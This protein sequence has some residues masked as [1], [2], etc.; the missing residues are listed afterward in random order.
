MLPCSMLEKKIDAVAIAALHPLAVGPY[1]ILFPDALF[2]PLDR[3]AMVS[4][5]GLHPLLILLGPFGQ[6]VFGEGVEAMHV[7]KEMDDVLRPC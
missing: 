7:A 3:D 5:K 1:I 4:G 2:R 6:N